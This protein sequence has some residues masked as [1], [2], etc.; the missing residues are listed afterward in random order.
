[1]KFTTSLL[2]FTDFFPFLLIAGNVYIVPF[3]LLRLEYW[4][5]ESGSFPVLSGDNPND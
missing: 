5:I 3:L 4:V 2:F 1:M